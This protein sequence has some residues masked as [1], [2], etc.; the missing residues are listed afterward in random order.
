MPKNRSQKTALPL[1]PSS[2]SSESE[3]VE[4]ELNATCQMYSQLSLERKNPKATTVVKGKTPSKETNQ[5]SFKTP[6]KVEVLK[7][8]VSKSTKKTKGKKTTSSSTNKK[9]LERNE[10][11]KNK[12]ESNNY[13]PQSATPKKRTKKGKKKKDPYFKYG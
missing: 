2:P 3:K 1:C 12:R 9:K 8:P 10:K 6:T 7:K 5:N 11:N 4:V 13:S